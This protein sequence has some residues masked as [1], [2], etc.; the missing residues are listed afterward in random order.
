MGSNRCDVLKSKLTPLEFP[1]KGKT[2]NVI[3]DASREKVVTTIELRAEVVRNYL[4]F[5]FLFSEIRLTARFPP[6]KN[7]LDVRRIKMHYFVPSFRLLRAIRSLRFNIFTNKGIIHGRYWLL[8]HEDALRK[9][10]F[11]IKLHI[12]IVKAFFDGKIQ[13]LVGN[14]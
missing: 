8:I 1:I 12:F 13:T 3:F 6:K 5:G 14:N 2:G 10:Q 7:V 9:V 4:R 11:L